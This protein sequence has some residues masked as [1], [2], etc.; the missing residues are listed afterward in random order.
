MMFS[1]IMRM[2][3]MSVVL[4]WLICSRGLFPEVN[5]QATELVAMMS[6]V[7]LGARGAP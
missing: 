1:L 3:M 4:L 2:V 6:I 5:N 7:V